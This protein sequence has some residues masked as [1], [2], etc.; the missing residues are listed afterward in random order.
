MRIALFTLLAM[1]AHA[2][3][4]AD[5]SAQH[6]QARALRDTL[7]SVGE[8]TPEYRAMMLKRIQESETAAA[9]CDRAVADAKRA[10]DARAAVRKR[11]MEA[12]AK[13]Q[14]AERF[15][16]DGLRSRPE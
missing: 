5:C 15:A 1:F 14:A 16:I 2:P 3:A 9:N 8:T 7:A 13:K 4:H 11:E 12:D 6:K 10:D